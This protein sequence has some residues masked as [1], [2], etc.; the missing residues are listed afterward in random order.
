MI[1]NLLLVKVRFFIIL[2]LENSGLKTLILRVFTITTKD[3][4]YC[5][6]EMYP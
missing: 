3:V 2:F 6:R 4:I 5:S 1:L